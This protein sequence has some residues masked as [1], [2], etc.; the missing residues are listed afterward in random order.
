MCIFVQKTCQQRKC[1][2]DHV[3]HK[4]VQKTDILRSALTYLVC[5]TA[6]R[7]CADAELNFQKDFAFDSPP[8][9]FVILLSERTPGTQSWRWRLFRVWD[10]MLSILWGGQV[11]WM[12]QLNAGAW[13]EK[14]LFVSCLK[15][16][17]ML[18]LL[19]IFS[20]QPTNQSMNFS[21]WSSLN[22]TN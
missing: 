1:Y 12:G 4:L 2:S 21:P 6:V 3:I 14:V 18:F 13:H 10:L 22:I 15:P 20:Q 5:L 16:T 19:I 17:T 7:P 11:W 8:Q 9:F